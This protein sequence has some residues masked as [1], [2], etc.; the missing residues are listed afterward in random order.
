MKAFVCNYL[1]SWWRIFGKRGVTNSPLFLTSLGTS[2]H[3]GKVSKTVSPFFSYLWYSIPCWNLIVSFDLFFLLKKKSDYQFV[4]PTFW[5][6]L[7]FQRTFWIYYEFDFRK[8]SFQSSD[9]VVF[10]FLWKIVGHENEI[11]KIGI[12]IFWRMGLITDHPI[13]VYRKWTQYIWLKEFW[14]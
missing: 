11:V 3:K 13:L 4:S 14:I 12:A 6:D 9:F 1:A 7:L 2:I 5:L 10:I 8:I